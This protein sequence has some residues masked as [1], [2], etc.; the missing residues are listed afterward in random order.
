[1]NNKMMRKLMVLSLLVGSFILIIEPVFAA[2]CN[3]I[4]TADAADFIGEIVGWIRIIVPALL[5]LL[6]CIDFG[7]AVISED[8]DSLKKAGAKFTKRCICA[9]AVFFVPLVVKVLIDITGIEGTLVDD[10]MCIV[11]ESGVVEEAGD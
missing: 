5:L 11:E 3:G 10:P 2:S 1:M 7:S 4:L 6:G 8:K 9:V